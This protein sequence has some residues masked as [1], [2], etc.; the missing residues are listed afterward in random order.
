MVSLGMSPD[1][2]I[3]KFYGEEKYGELGLKTKEE[4]RRVNVSVE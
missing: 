4:Y 3:L 1:K 2:I